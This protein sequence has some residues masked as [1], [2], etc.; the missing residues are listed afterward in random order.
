[1]FRCCD[2]KEYQDEETDLLN[3]TTNQ[4]AP[5]YNGRPYF[6]HHSSMEAN[7]TATIFDAANWFL[8]KESMNHKKLQKLCYYAQAWSLALHGSPMFKGDFEAWAHG[9]VNRQ[10]WNR[11]KGYYFSDILQDDLSDVASPLCEKYAELL[12]NVWETYGKYSGF[13]LEA[14]TLTHEELPWREARGGLPTRAP[15]NKKIGQK[16]MRTYYASQYSGDGLGE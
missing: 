15:S 14:L 9:P 3:G 2:F 13:Q 7:I 16:T 10:L 1:L 5:A 11:F 6:F 8:S 4:G 12:G